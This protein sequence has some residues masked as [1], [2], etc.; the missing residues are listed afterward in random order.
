MKKKITLLLSLLLTIIVNSQ[1]KYGEISFNK[2][3]NIAGKQRMLSQ[4]TS[5]AYLY[6]LETPSD[7][8]VKQEL[9]TS[10]LLFEKQNEILLKNSNS[11]ETKTKIE[12]VITLWNQ[13][14]VIF[15]KNP[16]LKNAE[17][18][19]NTNSIL[20]TKTDEVV[21]SIIID[22]EASH[23]SLD[24]ASLD[25][26]LELKKIINIC[27]KQRMLLQRLA[28]YY[29]ANSKKLQNEKSTTILEK[30]YTNI[31]D[32]ISQLL[33]SDF[34][35]NEIEEALASAMTSWEK[36]KTHKEELLKHKANKQDLYTR[37]NDLTKSF[38]EL[39]LLY[40]KIQ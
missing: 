5:K 24:D 11:K 20:L 32:A 8:K 38:N 9:L 28:L 6:L 10:K 14:K 29:Y 22:V 21:K 31:D 23:Q 34:N 37:T 26:N 3:I 18:I 7:L 25:K 19:I 40:E 39:T 33:I 1:E 2:A 36:I 15:E 13:L 17:K 16:T 30:I 4:K 12:E 35:N 27:G